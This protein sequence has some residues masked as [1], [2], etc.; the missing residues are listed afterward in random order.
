VYLRIYE[1]AQTEYGLLSCGIYLC[2]GKQPCGEAG[3]D[4]LELGV[5]CRTECC[6]C[7]RLKLYLMPS[8]FQQ[9][10]AGVVPIRKG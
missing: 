7:L 5:K 4:G 8:F 9:S 2:L 10:E 1:G 3:T 6:E